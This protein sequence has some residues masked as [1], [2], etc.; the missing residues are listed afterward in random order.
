MKFKLA[1]IFLFAGILLHSCKGKYEVP[2]A[3]RNGIQLESKVFN[4]KQAYLVFNDSVK[5]GEDNLAALGQHVNLE[6]VVDSSGWS[7]EN[8]LFYPGI[9][10]KI[11]SDD[12]NHVFENPDLMTVHPGGVP[13]EDGWLVR[14]QAVINTIDKHYKYFLVTFHVWDK[15]GKGEIKG[16]YKLHVK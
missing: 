14:I 5:L 16:S 1:A 6:L 8:G 9:S 4:V 15:K 7:V 12:G 11:E 3:F 13:I 2:P 10:E